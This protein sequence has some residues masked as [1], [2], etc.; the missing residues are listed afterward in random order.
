MNSGYQTPQH[1]PGV[2]KKGHEYA[3]MMRL[4]QSHDNEENILG[5]DSR[6]DSLFQVFSNPDVSKH[7]KELED[8]K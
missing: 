3:K 2:S 4:P 6:T 8:L 5:R 7:I 1:T